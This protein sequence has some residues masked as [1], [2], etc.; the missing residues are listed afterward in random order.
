VAAALF[1]VEAVGLEALAFGVMAPPA[2][3]GAT[4]EEDHGA[5]ARPV[6]R[7]EAHDVENERGAL[8]NPASLSPFWCQR[9][10]NLD[11]NRSKML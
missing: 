4:F 9:S 5:D 11:I 7:G 1:E 8:V 2:G 3:K 10:H 6:M